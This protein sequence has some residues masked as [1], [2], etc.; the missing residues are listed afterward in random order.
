[1]K[2]VVEGEAFE[3]KTNQKCLEV[4][5][6][7]PSLLFLPFSSL[8]RCFSLSNALYSNFN[9]ALVYVTITHILETQIDSDSS[10]KPVHII[11]SRR[12]CGTV[13]FNGLRTL[14][15]KAVYCIR[16]SQKEWYEKG[17]AMK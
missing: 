15:L 14:E 5:L 10:G 1:M 11:N 4:I 9:G 2:G 13:F 16:L 7:L 8:L 6:M 12:C 3:G 17:K